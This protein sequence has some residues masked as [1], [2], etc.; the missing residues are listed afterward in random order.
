MS[1][2][3]VSK[4]GNRAVVGDVSSRPRNISYSLTELEKALIN[5]LRISTWLTLDEV[6]E[7]LLVEN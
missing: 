5:G 1:L 3:T 2:P 7:T 4:W 6:W